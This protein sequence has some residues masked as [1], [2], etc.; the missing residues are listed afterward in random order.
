M[1]AEVERASKQLAEGT[2]AWEQGRARLDELLQ[3]QFAADR[4][5]EVTDADVEQAQRRLNAIANAAYRNPVPQSLSIALSIDLTQ[6]TQSLETVHVLR[7]TS[8]SQREALAILH[9][10]RVSASD[11]AA[12]RD[13]LRQLAQQAQEKLDDQLVALQTLAAQ[14]NKRLQAAQAR[15]EKVRAQERARLIAGL[16]RLNAAAAARAAAAGGGAECSAPADGLYANGF[17]P[18]SVLCPLK[19]APGQRLT[20]AAAAAFDRLSAARVAA[21]GA[22]LCVTDSYRDY[23]SQVD[24]FSRK[25]SLAATPGSSQHGWGLA[26]DLCGGV[27]NSS[28]EV[29]R[30]MK[31]NAP[32]FGF[33]HPAWAEPGGSKPEAW[34]WEYVG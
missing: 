20:G 12:Q 6:L 9:A 28:S 10:Q 8:S 3:R 22:P 2:I 26:V 17:L 5:L 33:V 16:A 7:R 15:L 11:L 4:T 14:T 18:T 32:A 13:S 31:A 34:H 19:M 21:T 30:W 24:V 29:F 1:Q 23:A 25:P 27:E